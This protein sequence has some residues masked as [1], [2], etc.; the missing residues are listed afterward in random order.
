MFERTVGQG[1]AKRVLSRFL[2]GAEVPTLMLIGPEGV[3]KATLAYEF[4]EALA[5]RYGLA[6]KVRRLTCQDVLFVSPVPPVPGKPR[7]EDFYES[8]ST[9]GINRIR[10]IKAEVV[11]PPIALNRKVVVIMNAEN[12]TLEAQNSMLKLLEEGWRRT[13]FIL[14]TS[15][16]HRVLPTI[17]S[18]SLKVRF[19]PLSYGDFTKVV[20]EEDPV[21]YELSGHSPGVALRLL[22]HVRDYRRVINLWKEYALG[23]L[24][25]SQEL[26]KKLNEGGPMLLRLGYYALRELHRD[27]AIDYRRFNRLYLAIRDTETGYRRY[28]PNPFLH[29]LA[30]WNPE[31]ST[32][33]V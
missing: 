15:H 32:V 33:E 18:R 22:S 1:V 31:Y 29:L 12:A 27:G 10:E 23:S 24:T 11:R 8:R 9:I 3:G 4:L 21:L 13:L 25:A 19:S 28:L 26:L 6:E 30:V 5:S 7:P 16:P 2:E 20:G 17:R 14:I